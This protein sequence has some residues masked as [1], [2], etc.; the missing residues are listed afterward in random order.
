MGLTDYTFAYPISIGEAAD[1]HERMPIE[2]FGTFCLSEEKR[3]L[4]KRRQEERMEEWR[5]RKPLREYLLEWWPEDEVDAYFKRDAEFKEWAD[6]NER[7]RKSIRG[8]ITLKYRFARERL[9]ETWDVFRHGRDD[10]YDW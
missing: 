9:A 10:E 7:W 8:R 6:K 1:M 5:N 4:Y 2:W 3:E